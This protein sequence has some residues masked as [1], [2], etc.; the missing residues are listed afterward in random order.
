MIFHDLNDD[1][2]LTTLLKRTMEGVGHLVS[3]HLEL[4]K[5]E[6]KENAT[7]FRS[8]IGLLM[9]FGAFVVVGYGFL[10]AALAVAL[11]EWVSIGVAL[12]IVGLANAFGGGIGLYV[13]ASR[14]KSTR[15][16]PESGREISE[17]A[18]ALAP[19]MERTPDVF[20]HAPEVFDGR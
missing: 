17:S 10:C 19:L 16:L 20:D 2:R 9:V 8:Q 18:E 3:E 4:A 15:M 7:A 11:S 12:L 13:A 5:L 1:R 6:L 14:I